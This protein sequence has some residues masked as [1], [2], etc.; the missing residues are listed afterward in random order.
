MYAQSVTLSRLVSHQTGHLAEKLAQETGEYAHTHNFPGGTFLNSTVFFGATTR[1]PD[2][3]I[4]LSTL[5][6][7]FDDHRAV[8][9]AN[10]LLI[11][12]VGI[13]DT[14]SDPRLV[15]YPVPGNDDTPC[16]I[17]LY[18]R[19]FKT[20]ILAGKAYASREGGAA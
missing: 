16:A 9:D 8:L 1:L 4:F 12:S 15:T 7:V 2:L 11:P 10:R 13:V 18:C 5:N 14:P 17:Q 19:L 3:L 6:N 20:A